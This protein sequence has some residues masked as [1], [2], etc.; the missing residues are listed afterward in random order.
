MHC[1]QRL[2][3]P[4]PLYFSPFNTSIHGITARDVAGAPSF[5][6][7]WPEILENV[8]GP[9]VAHNAAFD[10][11]VIRRSLDDAGIKYPSVSYY[12]TRVMA[13]QTWPGMPTYGLD[14]LAKHLGLVFQHHQAA[15][16][17]RVCASVA[18]AACHLHGLDALRD[19]ERPFVFTAGRLY[20]G[21]Y[22]PCHGRGRDPSLPGRS[23]QKVRASDFHPSVGEFDTEHPFF[24][25][26]F[27][28]TGV[29]S[30]LLR[31][32]AMQAVVNRGG[33]CGDAVCQHTDYLVLGQDG[34]VGYRAGFKSSKM[35]KAE[36]LRAR[37]LPI[38]ILSEA[39]FINM[40]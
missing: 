26:S 21:G 33:T 28:F 36:E 40:L 11:G 34:Y 39:D 13:K 4:D 3:R 31:K 10:I 18:L 32:D 38:E 22:V 16:D 20:P 30:A 23:S 1:E 2:I 5:S 17:A 27:V 29:M 15:E 14:H 9:L 35:K 19:F 37:G 12:C 24:G 6:E 7:L 25:N 8:S